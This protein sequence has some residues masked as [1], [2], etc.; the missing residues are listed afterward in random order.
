[1][2]S[3]KNLSSVWRNLEHSVERHE[4]AVNQ[5]AADIRKIKEQIGLIAEALEKIESVAY[6]RASN[7][8]ERFKKVKGDR[9]ETFRGLSAAMNN[10][11]AIPQSKTILCAILARDWRLYHFVIAVWRAKEAESAV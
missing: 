9:H 10:P 8:R 6:R 5:D 1:V 3:Q 11:F 7:P 4:E 2:A